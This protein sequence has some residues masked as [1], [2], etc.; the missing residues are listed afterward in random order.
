MELDEKKLTVHEVAKLTGITNRT[1]HYYDEIGL[2]SPSIVTEAKYRIYTED[3]LGRL[4]EILFFKEIG[5]SLK[6][7]KLLL[8]AL[9]YNRKEALERHLKILDLKSKRIERLICLVNDTLAGKRDFSFEAF[10][11][12]KILEE[13]AKFRKEI[14]KRWSAT[15][16]YQ[17]F[18]EFFSE[19]TEKERASKWND[20]TVFSQELFEQLAVYIHLSPTLPKVQEMVQEWQNYISENFYPC[21]I[22]MLSYLGELYTS[23]QRF[24]SYID[25][26][27]IGLAEFFNKAI[28]Y[29][30]AENAARQQT[31]IFKTTHANF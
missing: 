31:A 28:Q 18:S 24:L 22:E 25:R 20:L 29:Y 30:S 2:L 17:E 6:E 10:S 9:P 8:T 11:N 26:F 3:D 23:D 12:S 1:L 27:G 14:A 13:Q 16:E 19:H 7:I 15:K 21:S 5:F 4:Q